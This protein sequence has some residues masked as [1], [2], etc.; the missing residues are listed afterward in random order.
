MIAVRS[1]TF[2]AAAALLTACAGG[3]SPTADTATAA[4]IAAGE[5]L[6]AASCAECHGP[7]GEGTDEGPPL[8]DDVYRPGHH[9]D[10]A[11]LAAV[12]RGVPEH[13]WDFGPMEPVAGIGDDEVD[14]II[15]FVRT[16]Q[17]QAGID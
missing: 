14:D 6:F 3:G 5:A 8:V 16:L 15:A 10:G 1:P 17:R 9:G 12:R 7:T 13:H 11:F 2:L 4:D